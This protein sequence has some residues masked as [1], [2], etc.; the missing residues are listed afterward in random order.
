MTVSLDSIALSDELTLDIGPAPAA[1]NQ[2]R[3]IGGASCVQADGSSG[4]R[5]LTLSGE[6]DWTLGQIEQIRAL[7]SSAAT[8]TLVHHRGTF[9]VVISSTSELEPTVNYKDPTSDS[10]YTGP[11]TLIER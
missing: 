11:I 8:V 5:T 1:I 4:G 2:R 7:E 6:H 3:L 10:W 9:R